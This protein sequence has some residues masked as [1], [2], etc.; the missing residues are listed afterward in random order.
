MPEHSD[1][2]T[3]GMKPIWY[4]VGWLLLM[5]GLIVT[6]TGIYGL[7]SPPPVE[8]QTKLYHLHTGIWWGAI[9][10]VAGLIFLLANRNVTVK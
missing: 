5:I 4:F 8:Q 10:T 9:I 3:K 7:V 6:V 2:E 1:N